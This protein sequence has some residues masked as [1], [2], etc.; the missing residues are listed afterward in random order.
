MG[1]LRGQGCINRARLESEIS[2]SNSISK[3]VYTT[4]LF[5]VKVELKSLGC[6]K[7]R[8]MKEKA[9]HVPRTSYSYCVT[10]QIN[11][12]RTKKF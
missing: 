4:L 1:A 9:P 12:K 11:T 5:G 7:P 3:Y 6:R 2:V 10:A 8:G